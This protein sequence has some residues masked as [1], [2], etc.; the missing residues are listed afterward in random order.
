MPSDSRRRTQ[1]PFPS[2]VIK[3][4]LQGETSL[5]SSPPFSIALNRCASSVVFPPM[6]PDRALQ[7]VEQTG[8]RG[9][10]G[11]A[12]FHDSDDRV[13]ILVIGQVSGDL[14]C[15]LTTGLQRLSDDYSKH[16][17]VVLRNG[18]EFIG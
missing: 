7:L 2:S 12:V 8:V 3:R 14:L 16:F 6:P 15:G 13:V 4:I 17:P 10:T 5:P 1:W 18:F 11:I 9:G